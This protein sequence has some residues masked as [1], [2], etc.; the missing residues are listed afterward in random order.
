MAVPGAAVRLAARTVTLSPP[1]E[2]IAMPTPVALPVD[3]AVVTETV[4]RREPATVPPATQTVAPISPAVPEAPAPQD[5]ARPA[6]PNYVIGV[7]DLLTIIVWRSPELSGDVRVGSDGKIALPRGNPISAA[8]WTVAGLR[9]AVTEELKRCCLASPDVII[10]V[11]MI[12]SRMASGHSAFFFFNQDIAA[13]AAARRL[14]LA[15]SFAQQPDWNTLWRTL[16][17]RELEAEKN[18]AIRVQIGRR[19]PSIRRK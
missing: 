8:G 15:T 16:S 12:V 3:P 7:N 18:V 6:P 19:R 2:T 9:D 17:A 11:K 10:Q 5:A 13:D 14:D 1:A 4:R